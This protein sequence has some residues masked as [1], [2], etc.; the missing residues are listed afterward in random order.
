MKHGGIDVSLLDN[1]STDD[2]ETLELTNAMDDVVFPIKHGLLPDDA[3][4]DDEDMD[5]TIDVEEDSMDSGFC[6]SK[7]NGVAVERQD[8]VTSSCKK[9]AQAL[10]DDAKDMD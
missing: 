3:I 10:N 5:N 4:D 7:K 9:R 1:V 8:D 2:E 6:T